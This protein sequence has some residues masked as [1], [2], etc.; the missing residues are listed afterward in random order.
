MPIPSEFRAYRTEAAFTQ[1]FLHPLLRKLGFSVVLDYH[2]HE[3]LGKDLVFA[4]IDRFGL[5]RYHAMQVRMSAVVGLNAMKHLVDTARMAFAN[6]FVHPHTGQTETISGFYV[7]IAGSFSPIARRH[8]FAS[9]VPQQC[10]NVFLL[11]GPTLLHLDRWS[12]LGRAEVVQSRIAGLLNELEHNQ[13]IHERLSKP[14]AELLLGKTILPP[15]D[16][17][18]TLCVGLY[19]AEP[20]IAHQMGLAREYVLTANRVNSLLGM[21]VAVRHPST[22]YGLA[23]QALSELALLRPLA[24][25]IHDKVERFL[26]QLSPVTPQEAG[27]AEE[28]SE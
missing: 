23:D 16:R 1:R 8:F 13:R 18:L 7:A 28:T 25:H 15:A 2:G 9:L 20:F 12:S 14:L 4:E 10:Q 5:V 26:E 17:L 11:D 3:E 6:P 27:P 21:L 24:R 22:R 19:N